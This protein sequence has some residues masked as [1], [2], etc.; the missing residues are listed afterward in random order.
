MPRLFPRAP[1]ALPGGG[2]GVARATEHQYTMLRY[3]AGNTADIIDDDP[4][5]P[6]RAGHRP[7]GIQPTAERLVERQWMTNIGTGYIV[8]DL[9]RAAC[10]LVPV[11]RDIVCPVPAC[12]ARPGER[13]LEERGD[14]M[15]YVDRVHV[16]RY[17]LA[18]AAY[19]AARN[20]AQ[21]T[22]KT[23]LPDPYTTDVPDPSAYLALDE[24][25]PEFIARLRDPLEPGHV[26]IIM[27]T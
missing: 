21:V 16:A 9:G 11:R 17:N 14:R 7:P 22:S 3:W 1:A 19:A 20:R 25:A 8:T 23:G 15:V 27:S 2:F 18:V 26:G 12:R 13:C 24:I 10:R 4:G 6:T 5:W